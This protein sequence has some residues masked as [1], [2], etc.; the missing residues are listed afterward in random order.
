MSVAFN[1]VA[2]RT[3]I[4]ILSSRFSTYYNGASKMTMA[5][6]T[7]DVNIKEGSGRVKV[8]NGVPVIVVRYNGKLYAYVAVCPHAYCVLFD[9]NLRDSMIRCACHGERF[10]VE[11][12]EPTK[13]LAKEPLVK[14]NV[15]ARGGDVFV[16]VPGRDVLERI[17][18]LTRPKSGPP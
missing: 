15:E 3:I 16:E 13:G 1:D 12:G 17:V 6:F 2:S 7:K 18:D 5:W 9:V 4:V 10:N 14:L 8:V 11:T